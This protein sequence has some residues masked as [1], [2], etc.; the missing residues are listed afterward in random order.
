MNPNPRDA[1]IA[2][3]AYYT[4]YVWYRLGLPYAHLFKTP[5]GALAY[6]GS[7]AAGEWAAALVPG[8]PTMVQYLEQRHLSFERALETYSPDRVVELGA[9][10]SRRGLTWALDRDVPYVELDLPHMVAAKRAA[11]DRG[12]T[13]AARVKADAL[14]RTEARDILADDFADWLADTLKGSAR[15]AVVTE[16]VLPYF[17]LVEKL[18]VAQ[19]V[20]RALRAIGGGLFVSDHR[21]REGGARVAVAANAIRLGIRI[22]T[23]G[24]G[25]APDFESEDA[26][27]AFFANTGFDDAEPIDVRQIPQVAHI[28]V[29]S[30]VWRAHVLATR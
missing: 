12:L 23:L 11:L 20:G 30:R 15:P 18:R 19:S 7:K 3:T 26:V 10:L 13:G 14:L 6:W 17:E 29:P 2:P 4:S 28:P 21:A 24:R 5:Q 9:G 25:A 22:L 1:R 27:R 16:G 8:L